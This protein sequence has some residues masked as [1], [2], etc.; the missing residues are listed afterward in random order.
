MGK[1]REEQLRS[2]EPFVV[3]AGRLL[4]FVGAEP[5]SRRKER[6]GQMVYW[7]YGIGWGVLFAI[8]A[9][10]RAPALKKGR[11]P[12]LRIGVLRSR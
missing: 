3:L 2:E 1:E 7:G 10:R 6:L 12:P 11:G 5:T 4:E 8:A 9:R